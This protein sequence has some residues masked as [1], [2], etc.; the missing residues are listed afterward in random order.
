MTNKPKKEFTCPDCDNPLEPVIACGAESYFCN[1]C[2]KQ[3][4]RSRIKEHPNYK[5]KSNSDT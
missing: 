5:A 4:S 3:I 1:A 2:K